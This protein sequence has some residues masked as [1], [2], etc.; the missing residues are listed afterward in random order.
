MDTIA[1]HRYWYKNTVCV[2]GTALT[3]KHIPVVKRLTKKIYLC[4]D[5]DEAW[6]KATLSSIEMLK[7]KD[8]EVKIIK[9]KW[10]KDPDDFLSEGWN[11]DDLINN[12]LTPIWYYFSILSKKYD[13][14][15]LDE[16]KKALSEL[17]NVLKSYSNNIEVDFYL[18][19]ISSKLDIKL[20]V[21][22]TEYRRLR[23]QREKNTRKI[24]MNNPNIEDIILAYI[25][26]NPELVKIFNEKIL[27]KSSLWTDLQNILSAWVKH[28]DSLDLDKQNFIK[29]LTIDINEKILE[30]NEDYLKNQVKFLINKINSSLFKKTKQDFYNKMKAEPDNLDILKQYNDFIQTASKNSIK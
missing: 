25:I 8:C 15:S 10:W 1:L 3:E 13:L 19:E 28:F 12:A 5:W 16:K 11:F 18:K 9:I 6:A 26:E 24:K 17:L 22:Y 14:S 20:E 4:F 27:F 29:W 30:W 2:S 7:N 21:I 23:W